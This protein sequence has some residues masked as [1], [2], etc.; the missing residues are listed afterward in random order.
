MIRFIAATLTLKN[1]SRLL[2]NIPR[3]LIRSASGTPVSAASCS[4]LSLNDNQLSS[5]LIM[6]LCLRILKKLELACI[7]IIYCKNS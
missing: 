6:V 3:N 4:T 5:R 1:S 2:E 7:A